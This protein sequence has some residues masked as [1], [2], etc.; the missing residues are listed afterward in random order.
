M[1]DKMDFLKTARDRMSEAIEG[2]RENRDDGLDDLRNLAGAEGQWP[3]SVKNEREADNRPCITV[4][5][6][7][8]FVRQVTGDIRRLNPALKVLPGDSAASDDGAELIGGLIRQI[9]YQSSATSVYEGAGESAAQC[10]IGHWRVRTQYEDENSFEQE[11]VLERV[12]NPFSVYWDPTAKDPTRKDADFCFVTDTMSEAEFSK[13]YPK[14]AT[15]SAE[16]DGTT[17]GMEN[18][19]ISGEVVVAE[20]FWIDRKDVTIYKLEDGTVT[21]KEPSFYVAKRVTQRPQVMWAKISGSDVLEGPREFPGKHIPII[22]VVG[23]EMYIGDR[24]ARTSVIRHAKDAQRLYNYARSTEAEVIALQPKAPYLGTIKQFQGLTKF[25][26]VAHKAN[27]PYLPYNPDEK[28]PGPPQRQTPPV[29][30]QGL[31]QQAL[32]AAD[33]MKAATGIY[34]AGLGNQSSETSGVA[35]RQRQMESDVS[36]SIYS[37]NLAKSIEHCGRVIIGMIPIIYDTP[38]ILRIVGEDDQQEMVGVNQQAFDDAGQPFTVNDLTTGR[39]DVRVTVGPNY[40]TRRQE[41]RE[42]MMQFVQAIPQAGAVAADLVAKAQEWP[43]ADKI[44]D[45]LK[46]ALPPGIIGIEDLPPEEQ[47]QAMM[48]QQMAQQQQAQQAQMQAQAQQLELRKSAA[49]ATE[50][51]AQAQEAGFDAMLK[52]IEVSAQSGAINAAINNAVQQALLASLQ[53]INPQ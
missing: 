37:D 31:T 38:R 35:I 47:Q 32:Q 43:D 1:K 15:A 18:W 36:T 3:E 49:E 20:Y 52:Q 8:G 17:D 27:L 34:D 14:A 23:E 28:A 9:E 51:E 40:A 30:S 50:A 13:Q 48:Q 53:G 26:D 39:Y 10:G 44:A 4:N 41:T 25:W 19:R 45:R 46:K 22:S 12:N 11:I 21:D 2:D 33:D 5:R 29:A 6:L 42:G 16:H 24:V 7:T